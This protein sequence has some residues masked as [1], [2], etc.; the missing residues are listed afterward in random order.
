MKILII[1]N[2]IAGIS[3]A[4]HIR[5]LSNHEICVISNE[6]E[7]F[8]SRTA[9][10]YIYM[11]QLKFEH[12]QPYEKTF[13]AK[14]RIELIYKEV[15]SLLPNEQKIVFS[16][17]TT[18]EYDKL[19]LAT[20]SLPNKYDWETEHCTGVQGLYFYSDLQNME[21]YSQNLQKAVIVGGGLIGIE[22]AEMFHSRHIPVT[23]LVREK[24]FWNKILPKEESEMINRHILAQKGIELRLEEELA[25]LEADE[26][27]RVKSILTKN[28]EK[29]ECQFVGLAAGVSPNIALAKGTNLEANKGFLVNALLETNVKNIYAMGDCAELRTPAPN[30]NAIEAVWYTGKLMAPALAHTICGTPTPYK[31]GVW[32]NSAKFF[33]IEYQ[34][35][36]T[37][38]PNPSPEETHL[39]WEHTDATK[40]IRIAYL[41][42]NKQV[43]GFNLM[44]IRYRQEVCEKWILEKANIGFV[45]ANLEKAN[46]D[47][48]FFRKYEKEIKLKYD[49]Q[50]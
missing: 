16:D 23:F 4:R 18:K 10:M 45:L 20:G 26:N 42:Q 11:G 32:F 34:V 6:T 33:D 24:S 31:Q 41:T 25:E 43:I 29:I 5:K 30:R 36:G 38:S 48:E 17:G 39:Y 40:S 22:M 49:S 21:K 46:F 9:L 47:P 3:V 28:G 14:N 2:G 35:Y 50:K 12:T 8:Y 7:Y 44:G 19:I 15:K 1:G 37:I 13:W 27:G